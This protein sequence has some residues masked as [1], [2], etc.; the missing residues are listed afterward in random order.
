MYT[1]GQ[2]KDSVAGLL[3]GTDLN[4][5]TNLDGAIHR[6]VRNVI[7][8]ADVP[9]TM[10]KQAY[11]LYDGVT[12]YPAPSNIF[13]GALLDFRPQGNSRNTNDYVYKKPIAEWDRKK[14]IL[15]NGYAIAFEY[16]KGTGIARIA[17]PKPSPKIVLDSCDVITGWTAGGNASGLARDTT[18]Y[19]E[20]P[21]S[22]RFNLDASGSQGYIEKTITKVDL[23]EYEGVGVIFL[24]V[25]LPSATAITSIGARI[26]SDSSNYFNISNTTGFLGSW[27]SVEY[28]I[29]ALDLSLATETGTVD[30]E[31]VDYLRIYVNYDGTALTNFYL[32][33]C[34]IA[35]PSPHEMLFYSSAVFLD[36][37]ANTLSKE[38]TS[39]NNYLVFND[40]AYTLLEYEAAL[41][42]L[43]QNG[44][45]I[46]EGLGQ[47]YNAK[48]HG[49][50][51]TNFGL[52]ALYR[53]DNPSE[54]IRTVGNWYFD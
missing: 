8:Y 3:S 23:T 33:A 41:T 15:P 45:S 7:Q 35:L 10:E 16:Q 25:R 38:I 47:T 9:D 2:L 49:S 43:L 20:E 53:A 1:V 21:S 32:G 12:E 4:N 50:G 13:G 24:A 22:I 30:I 39:D 27:K 26:G 29:I 52:Y 28:T 31:N 51:G 48:L 46:A 34:F 6:A 14:N 18:V 37:A 17:T 19:Y 40:S 42:I 11:T 44:G 54:E 36:S 5:V